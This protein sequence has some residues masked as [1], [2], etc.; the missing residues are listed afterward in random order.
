M[1]KDGWRGERGV[2]RT[3]RRKGARK[4]RRRGGGLGKSRGEEERV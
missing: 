4:M 1:G 3:R 2:R